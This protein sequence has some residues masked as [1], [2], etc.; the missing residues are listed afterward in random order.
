MKETIVASKSCPSNGISVSTEIFKLVY[1]GS[2]VIDKRYTSCMLPWIVAEI[3]RKCQ[4]QT[5]DVVVG[6]AK[7]IG[8]VNDTIVEHCLVS[9]S[10][11]IKLEGKEASTFAYLTKDTKNNTTCSCHV[12]EAENTTKAG[13]FLVT[14]KR[15]LEECKSKLPVKENVKTDTASREH[16]AKEQHH[17]QYNV[18]YVGKLAVSHRKAPPTLIDTS[19]E[20]FRHHNQQVLLTSKLNSLRTE[21]N[22]SETPPEER[23]PTRSPVKTM[24]MDIE[25]KTPEQ[26]STEDVVRPRSVS[27]GT[28]SSAMD[29]T[30]CQA[31]NAFTRPTK[32]NRKL[33]VFSENR[34]LI[35]NISVHSISFSSSVSGRILMERKVQEISFCQQGTL[36]PEHFGFICHDPKSSYYHCYVF[37]AESKDEVDNL[38]KSLRGAFNSAW[39]TVGSTAPCENCPLHKLHCLCQHL[40][41][42]KPADQECLIRQ[43]LMDNFGDSVVDDL[44][45]KYQA[46]SKRRD[47]VEHNEIMMSL[48]RQLYEEMQKV[49]RHS[50]SGQSQQ[51]D[52]QAKERPLQNKFIAKAKRSLGDIFRS[53]GRS[54]RSD[55]DGLSCDEAESKVGGS[56]HQLTTVQP[57]K[58]V[59]VHE[60][61]ETPEDKAED[62]ENEAAAKHKGL[63]RPKRSHRRS[64]SDISQ[65]FKS[66][67]KVVK[68]PNDSREHVSDDEH[69]VVEH[70]Q[71]QN[72][73]TT[74]SP[75]K[76]L[77][78]KQSYRRAIFDSVVTPSKL[79]KNAEGLVPSNIYIPEDGT[80]KKSPDQLRALW[81]KAIMEQRLLIRM[82]K[83]N[84]KLRAGEGI[85]KNKRLKLEYEELLPSNNSANEMWNKLLTNESLI[86]KDDLID[87]VKFGVPKDRRGEIWRFLLKQDALRH[88]RET[89]PSMTLSYR[90][91]KE[92]RSV[93]QHA[94][95]IDCNR[96]FPA[97]PYFSQHVG[98]GQFALFTLL[99]V[100]SNL[101]PEL[102]Y[103]QGL[104]FVAGILLMHLG[105]EEAFE[106]LKHLNYNYGLRNQYMPDMAGLRVQFYQY[107]RLLHD[108]C[109]SL[110]D[111][112]E[113][114]EVTTTL[115]AASWFLTL[116]ASLFPVS[117]ACR[118]LDLL[119]FGGLEAVFKVAITLVSRF[120]NKIL[121]CESFETIVDFLKIDL[122]KLA[123][124]EQESIVN[125]VLAMDIG[126][127]LLRFEVEYQVFQEE[128][129]N[130]SLLKPLL[131]KTEKL[132]GENKN[133]KHRS[134]VLKSE[135]KQMQ[136]NEKALLDKIKELEAENTRLR[137]LATLEENPSFGDNNGDLDGDVSGDSGG[138]G[139]TSPG[140]VDLTGHS[141]EVNDGDI[142]GD[143]GVVYGDLTAH[144]CVTN[145]GDDGP[146]YS[147]GVT[148]CTSPTDDNTDSFEHILGETDDEIDALSCD[149]PLTINDSLCDHTNSP[150]S[151]YC[152]KL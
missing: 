27:D 127:K 46:E 104:S 67:S 16:P 124:D 86:D 141:F 107:S 12:F 90:E 60:L 152:T 11:C 63:I 135:L 2:L 102:G 34:S 52:T 14:L 113:N 96:T 101:D 84:S 18:T 146:G 68:D 109:P 36:E 35:M 133:L 144:S 134:N 42:Q 56:R 111:H 95:L 37:R 30:A 22:E 149:S 7:V 128:E 4:K 103:C 24:S 9:I 45:K 114:Y 116:F 69:F 1:F 54:S 75:K 65:V 110:H 120:Q 147:P 70:P 57:V 55:V 33:S 121:A 150:E 53:K 58:Q 28:P 92:M 73:N 119:C 89:T 143:S 15:A 112:F 47:V 49:H 51:T 130:P 71:S 76:T 126:D 81:R 8:T 88:K 31:S 3:K 43:H 145:D 85:A 139:N 94:I 118:V 20:R 87:A 32:S 117:F 48:L 13:R 106:V 21:Q 148:N 91:L 93:H 10:K 41:G 78:R 50:P 74:S 97:H 138:S 72:S 6:E 132:A 100:Y 99:K 39:Q 19:V 142:T 125:D 131:E 5:L 108:A 115:Y 129:I 61:A 17:V 59:N 25:D 136:R 26:E 98:V 82:E 40:Q 123:V 66:P 23:H 29:P 137:S 38:M 62:E 140:F 105:E 77:S 44:R 64:Y 151:E 83:E 122:P 79:P 80:V